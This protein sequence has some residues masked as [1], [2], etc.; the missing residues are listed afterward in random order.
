[1]RSHVSAVLPN[2]L[3][4]RIAISGLMLDLPL[5]T[6]LSAC[7]VTPRTLAPAVTDSPKGSRQSCE[8]NVRDAAG[9]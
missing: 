7:R 3:V 5:T 8:C 1:M 4:S 9:S 6:L 2:A